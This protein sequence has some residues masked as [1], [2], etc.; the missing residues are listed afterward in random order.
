MGRSRRDG[1]TA[2]AAGLREQVERWRGSREKGAA[3]PEALWAAATVLARAHGAY[4]VSRELG[5]CY[6][7]VRR[8]SGWP[9]R[10]KREAA[11]SC[12][13]VE[14]R[15]A[16]ILGSAPSAGPL[17]EVWDGSGAHLAVRLGEQD[18]LDVVEVVRAFLS[19][20]G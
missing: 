2:W 14:V 12:G 3:M 15:A 9:G 20:Q 1:E 8:R 7:T 17:V 13:F 19:R 18:G 16:Q 5:L 6:D 11:G 4:A 10:P